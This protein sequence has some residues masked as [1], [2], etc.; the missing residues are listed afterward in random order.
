MA[1]KF[2]GDWDK[3]RLRYV[4][5]EDSLTLD[6]LSQEPGAPALNTLKK[7]SSKESWTE[8]RKRFRHQRDTIAHHD[9]HLAAAASEV[10]K[11]IDTAEMLTRHMKALK[12]IGGK[13]LAAINALDP[14]DLKP[15]EALN[16]IKFAIEGER[17]TE[18]LATER[19]DVSID[20][21][22]QTIEVKL[23]DADT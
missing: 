6:A 18:G 21:S 19:Q 15:T 5:G 11:L 2:D 12:M 16:Y 13:G 17:L 8:Q 3:W 22:I 7:R 4:G 10:T 14:N 9:A 1:G 23:I 20:S